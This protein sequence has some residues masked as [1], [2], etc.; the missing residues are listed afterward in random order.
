V[1]WVVYIM[2]RATSFI[3]KDILCEFSNLIQY[4]GRELPRCP[5]FHMF[6]NNCIEHVVSLFH[7]EDTIIPVLFNTLWKEYKMC[8]MS[9]CVSLP[10]HFW[11]ATELY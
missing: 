8:K 6:N 9:H 2:S 10:Q 3:P 7:Q 4:T 1:F 11:R 5:Q